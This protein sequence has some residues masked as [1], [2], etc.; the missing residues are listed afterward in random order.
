MTTTT[1][2][3]T[4]PLT[5]PIDNRAQVIEKNTTDL[6]EISNGKVQNQKLEKKSKEE[7]EE[8][9]EKPSKEKTIQPEVP[10][11]KESNDKE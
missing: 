3:T 2:T 7:R 10:K 11:E 1:T 9:I 8:L 6:Y 5:K 4:T